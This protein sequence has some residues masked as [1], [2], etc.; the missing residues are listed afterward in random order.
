MSACKWSINC[1]QEAHDGT[2]C[3]FHLK[4]ARGLVSGIVHSQGSVAGQQL[5]PPSAAALKIIEKHYPRER[6][7]DDD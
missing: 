1:G 5:V 2:F 7:E 3:Y 4:R 6:D